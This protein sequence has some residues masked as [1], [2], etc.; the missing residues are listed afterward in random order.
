MTGYEPYYT[1]MDG[2]WRELYNP[3]YSGHYTV[4]GMSKAKY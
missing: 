4:V 1:D 3:F 2:F